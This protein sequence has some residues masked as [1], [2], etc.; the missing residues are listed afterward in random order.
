LQPTA[1]LRENKSLRANGHD[2]VNN[3]DFSTSRLHQGKSPQSNTDPHTSLALRT[4]NYGFG[5]QYRA[6]ERGHG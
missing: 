6:E 1:L 2:M 3:A 4:G 5:R